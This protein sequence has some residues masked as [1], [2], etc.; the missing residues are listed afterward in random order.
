MPSLLRIL[1]LTFTLIATSSY[2]A[3]AK[4]SEESIREI[5]RI[6]DAKK[7]IDLMFSQMDG[8]MKTT[9]A[10]AMGRDV[11][12]EQQAIV[13]KFQKKVVEMMKAEL[14]WEKLEPIYIQIYQKTLTQDEIDGMITFYKSP[15]GDAVIK[16]LPAIMQ[17]SMAMM[18]NQM[19][20]MA[21]KIQ[22]M[23]EESVREA[24]AVKS[25]KEN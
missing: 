9:M 13:E 7:V 15:A 20:N 18:Q 17:E 24:K 6:V 25:S 22:V 3:A 2:A 14:S 11:T 4:P 16:K 19:G 10:Q 21:Q 8:M 23:M 5:L 12:P 1:A